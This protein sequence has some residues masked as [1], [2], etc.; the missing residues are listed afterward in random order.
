MDGITISRGIKM[1]E[2]LE[3]KVKEQ[4]KKIPKWI[5]W[6]EKVHNE[7]KYK[8]WAVYTGAVVV[9]GLVIYGMLNL[10]HYFDK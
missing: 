1:N 4:E 2:N 5:R 8:F 10:I 3:N 6:I 9:G 7:N